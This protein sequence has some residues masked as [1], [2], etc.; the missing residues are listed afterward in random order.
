MI[1]NAARLCSIVKIRM[2][3]I[4]VKNKLAVN[5]FLIFDYSLQFIALDFTRK[6]NPHT[7]KKAMR[8][9]HGGGDT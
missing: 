5:Q 6:K 4:I 9:N 1:L 3:M 7:T 8:E 2:R